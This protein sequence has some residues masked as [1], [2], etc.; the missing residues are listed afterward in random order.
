[1]RTCPACGTEN[2]EDARFCAACGSMLAAICGA[3]GEPMP[4][5]AR[6]CP[7]CGAAAT[8]GP[9]EPE[10][11]ASSS[12]S[13]SPTSPGSTTLGRAARSRSGCARSW[14][15]YFAAMREEI[16][17]EG[18]T[19]E[20]FI[21]DA[22]MAAFG[23]PTA[24]EDDPARAVRAAL[25]MLHR[26]DAVNDELA[27]SARRRARRSASASTPARCSRRPIRG[28]AR[29]MVTGDAVNAAARLQTA[30][31][32]GT[33]VVGERTA[34]GARA[35]LP[36]RGPRPAGAEGQGRAGRRAPSSWRSSDWDVEPRR[37]RV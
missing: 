5:D 20:K 1:M 27:A 30:A 11:S 3:C 21:G 10:R 24:H 26:L 13:C 31:E 16:E 22:V 23:V 17:A 12:R 33:V 35:R 4:A 15:A 8:T 36:L 9:S 28:R 32:P 25:R 29:P 6:F 18:G 14:I 37:A 7:A 2:H 19:V 34:R